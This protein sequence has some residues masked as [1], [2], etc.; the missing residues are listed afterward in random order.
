M[1]SYRFCRP[2]DIPLLIDG[3]NRC[4]RVHFPNLPEVT[5]ATFKQ[6]IRERNLWAS[7]CVVAFEGKDIIGICIGC[8]RKKETLILQVGV[9]PD[10]QRQGHGRH[11]LKSLSGKL[12]V[13]GPPTL[14]AELPVSDNNVRAF[15]ESVG[16]QESEVFVDFSREEKLLCDKELEFVFPVT[17]NEIKPFL[18]TEQNEDLSWNRTR[19]ALENR[20]DDLQALAFSSGEKLE[21]Y[22]LYRFINNKARV[23]VLRLGG[24]RTPFQEKCIEILLRSLSH[25]VSVP[26]DIPKISQG[27]C[28]YSVFNNLQFSRGEEHIRYWASAEAN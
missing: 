11:L 7:S 14:V 3:V 22:A 13:L 23:E 21:A 27:E 10:F 2:D 25:S 15:F 8:K 4:Y 9:H 6:D 12:A 18:L 1:P 17:Y 24:E 5:L 16:F 20:K 26:I 19:E 28:A